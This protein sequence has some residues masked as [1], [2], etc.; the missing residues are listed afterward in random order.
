MIMMSLVFP[1]R[2]SIILRKFLTAL[3]RKGL[4]PFLPSFVS[5]NFFLFSEGFGR[6]SRSLIPG[7]STTVDVVGAS[8]DSNGPRCPLVNDLGGAFK[9]ERKIV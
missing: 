1:R 3:L 8:K 4:N 9:R 2:S 6:D 7:G 5:S